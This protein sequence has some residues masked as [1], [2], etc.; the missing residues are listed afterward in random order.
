M[1]FLP[2]LPQMSA[3]MHPIQCF[4]KLPIEFSRVP[5]DTSE[6]Q[7]LLCNPGSTGASTKNKL[8]PNAHMCS[9]SL[10]KRQS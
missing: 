1:I 9:S 5:F 7:S 6:S 3:H 4:Q 2:T 10:V 8:S